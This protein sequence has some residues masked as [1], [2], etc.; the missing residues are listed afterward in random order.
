M[1]R[2]LG[3]R[4]FLNH[5]DVNVNGGSLNIYSTSLWHCMGLLGGHGSWKLDLDQY[6]I[7]LSA[8]SRLRL[9]TLENWDFE[10]VDSV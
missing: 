7:F 1:R 2:L 9:V 6:G 3:S 10:T 4:L 8:S 5:P